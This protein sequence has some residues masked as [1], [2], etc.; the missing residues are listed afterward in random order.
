[1]YVLQDLQDVCVYCICVYMYGCD[2]VCIITVRL[3]YIGGNLHELYTSI[4][5]S[6]D[7]NVFSKYVSHCGY[8]TRYISVHFGLKRIGLRDITL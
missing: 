4:R 5:F 3:K 7:G 1:M 2:C 6:H 8:L